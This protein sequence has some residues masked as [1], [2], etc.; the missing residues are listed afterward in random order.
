MSDSSIFRVAGRCRLSM[1]HPSPEARQQYL[2][3]HPGA[4]VANHTVKKNSP[5]VR[6]REDQEELEDDV[7]DLSSDKSPESIAKM[8][9]IPVDE[10]KNILQKRKPKPESELSKKRPIDDADDEEKKEIVDAILHSGQ[11]AAGQL[12]SY[13][14]TQDD[15]KELVHKYHGKK[16]S[17]ALAVAL[18]Y[19]LRRV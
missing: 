15:F 8:V 18:R 4:D 11:P 14:L 1:E 7:V 10:V 9:R 17:A 3:N 2:K 5:K 6:S 13:G 16:K 12:R 19:W